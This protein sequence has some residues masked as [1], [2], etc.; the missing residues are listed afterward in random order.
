MSKTETK[1]FICVACPVGCALT[2]TIDGTEVLELEGNTCPRGVTYARDEVANPMRTFTSTVRVGG[3][4]LP[5]CPVRSRTPLPL[6]KVFDVTK[7]VAKVSLP[8][9]ITIGQVI[10][11]NICGTGTDIIA[12]RSLGVR[13]R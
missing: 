12:C 9:P 2:A 5:V 10:I 11:E 13:P 6:K 8:A 3:G 4:A 7:E 1:K